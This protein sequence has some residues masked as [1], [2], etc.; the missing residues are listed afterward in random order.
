MSPIGGVGINLAIQDAVATANILAD[1]LRQG[2]V[3]T[4]DLRKVQTRR[5]LP[6][7]LTQRLQVIVQ[8]RVIGRVIASHERA[9]ARLAAQ[10][11][12]A[13]SG[14]PPDSRAAHRHGVPSRA[15]EDR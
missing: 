6:T 5:E 4:E 9:C 13:V 8:N 14:A 1:R 15:C 12:A 3:T 11:L 10:A 7:R 2:S